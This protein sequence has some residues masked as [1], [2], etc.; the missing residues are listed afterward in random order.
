VRRRR[1]SAWVGIVAAAALTALAFGSS[2]GGALAGSHVEQPGVLDIEV[3]F[4]TTSSMAPAIEQAK[5]DGVN[6]VAGVREAFPDTHFALVSFRDYGNSGGDYEVLQPMTGDIAATQAAFQRL[7]TASNSSPF[8]TSA[9]EY[10]LALQKSY[11]DASIGWRPH[12]RKVVV[13]IGDAQPHGAG[14]R[15]LAGCTDTST[16]HYGLNTAEVLTGMRAAE[17]TLVMVR[18]ISSNTSA[19]LECYESMA[20]RAYTGGAARN[21]GDAGL[22]R[23]IVEL[24]QSAL[25]PVVLRPDVG[26]ALSRG[27]LGYTAT[28]SNPNSFAL[29]LRSIDVTMPAG[30]S[31]RSGSAAGLTSADA[32]PP[33]TVNWKLERVLAPSGKVSLHFRASAARRPGRYPVQ[34]AL[35]L[36]L[37]GGHAIVST[38]RAAMRIGSRLRSLT[39][40]TRATSRGRSL[41]GGVRI[42]FP[43]GRTLSAGKLMGRRI[44][45]TS[46][47]GRSLTLRVRS[48]RLISFGSPTVL[49]LALEVERVRGI[50]SCSQGTRGSAIVTDDQSF[51]AKG[52]RR[53]SIV[54][55]FG[56]KCRVA[57]GRWSN[58]GGGTGGAQV[59]VTAK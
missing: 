10:N 49:K 56:R 47:P 14:T 21:G 46:G 6:L 51:N 30:F 39:V 25:A 24:V 55:A 38:T 19:S 11:T 27:M 28:V 43:G 35:R 32:A 16:D 2:S 59:S 3:A 58:A 20:E 52:L 23:L 5:K 18:Q 50:R 40:A 7:R 57:T 13:V 36:A 9:E 8:N 15:G 53:D 17:R 4:D 22:A 12:A 33:T 42:A 48:H 44:T 29:A 45:F 41:R 1:T 26:V 31:Y 54:I 34:A 37:P